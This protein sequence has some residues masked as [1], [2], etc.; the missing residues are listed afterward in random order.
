MDYLYKKGITDQTDKLAIARIA[1]K[2][3]TSVDQVQIAINRLS[4]K[5]LVRKIYVQGKIG[6]ELTPK[7][8]SAREVSAKAQVDLVTKQ[9]MEAIHLG[10]KAKLRTSTINK[11]KSIKDKW[12]NYQ[13]PDKRLME[14]I[15]QETAKLLATTKEIESIQPLCN[16]DPQNYDQEFIQYKP[17]IENLTQ[18]NN[19]LTKLVNKYTKIKEDVRSIYDDFEKIKKTINKYELTKEVTDEMSRLKT[20]L[21]QLKPIQSQLESFDKEKIAQFEELKTKLADN[22]GLLE[23]LK[24]PTHQFSPIK[25]ESSAEKRTLYPDPEGPIKYER[26]TSAY[27][28]EEKCRRCGTKRKSTPVNI[29]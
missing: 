20:A 22:F 24:K 10:R 11:M 18:Q 13:I 25:R 3:E 9:L 16:V 15:E 4:A 2:I 26:K 1:A 29:G 8:K 12:Q 14:E 19:N 17:K 7:G 21:D 5:N 6:F 28:S 23:F 27:S